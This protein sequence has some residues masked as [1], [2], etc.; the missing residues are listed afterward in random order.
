MAKAKKKRL[1][2]DFESQLEAGNLKELT[3][4]FETHDIDARGGDSKQTA[5]AFDQCPDD[6]TRWLVESGADLAAEDTYGETPLHARSRGRM[7]RIQ[8]LLDLGADVHHGEKRQGTP[9]HAA[10]VTCDFKTAK[11]LLR[12]G[13]RV[14]ALNRDGETPLARALARCSNMLIPAMSAFAELLLSAGARRTPEMKKWVTR[15]GTNF[16]F[17]RAGFNPDFLEETS[18]GLEKLYKLFGVDPVARRVVHD[19]KTPIV[20]RSSS[21]QDQHQELWELLVPSRGAAATVQGEVIRITGKIHRELEVNGGANWD[22]EFGKM[23]QAF[24]IHVS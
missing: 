6:L 22:R 9:L 8:I 20:A 19:G 24:L 13:A 5:L 17:H 18:A 11:L 3:A 15:I 16:E 2:K 4:L 21:W 12:H 7:G 10:A 1:P 14:D 23:A